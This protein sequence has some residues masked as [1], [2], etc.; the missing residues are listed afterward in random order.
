MEPGRDLK[1][2]EESSGLDVINTE[3]VED[4]LAQIS[5]LR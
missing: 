4:V 1:Y 5:L 2:Q 3:D